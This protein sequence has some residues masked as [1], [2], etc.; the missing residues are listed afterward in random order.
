M[1]FKIINSFINRMKRDPLSIDENQVLDAQT[2]AKSELLK[3]L[4]NFIYTAPF[5]IFLGLAFAF[6]FLL[7]LMS[8]SMAAYYFFVNEAPYNNEQVNLIYISFSA[9]FVGCLIVFPAFII[10]HKI[11]KINLI[12]ASLDPISTRDGDACQMALDLCQA[13]PEAE[14]MRLRLIEEG[15]PVRLM[16][17]EA[18][19][20][21]DT[22][23]AVQKMRAQRFAQAQLKA[24][25]ERR[26]ECFRLHGVVS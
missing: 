10:S 7:P 2:L 23:D 11:D 22:H 25:Q 15:R 17:L 20:A 3:P 12:L 16:H 14:L 13:L 18:M 4:I 8:L 19:K 6:L 1:N 21:M 24:D 26:D 9:F 5:L